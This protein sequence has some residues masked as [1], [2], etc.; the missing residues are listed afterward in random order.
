MINGTRH[1]AAPLKHAKEYFSFKPVRAA[2]R[3][4]GHYVRC[5]MIYSNFYIKTL[6]KQ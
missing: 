6:I 5:P 2:M 1:N 3:M 4:K